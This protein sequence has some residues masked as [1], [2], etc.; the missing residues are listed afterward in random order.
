[1]KPPNWYKHTGG[2][3]TK[4][5]TN[6]MR[7]KSSWTNKKLAQHTMHLCTKRGLPTP[8]LSKNP[9]YHWKKVSVVGW[10]SWWNQMNMGDAN[11]DEDEANAD[12]DADDGADVATAPP[13]RRCGPSP[14]KS[15]T[16]M[17][18][19][20]KLL[21]KGYFSVRDWYSILTLWKEKH[22]RSSDNVEVLVNFKIHP[23]FFEY[24]FLDSF[25]SKPLHAISSKQY[26]AFAE[27]I[28]GF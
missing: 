24:W 14:K 5:D 27:P 15:G 4:E 21:Q 6:K 16:P 19:S 26:V 20:L 8:N 17:R 23:N 9:W 13:P 11:E 10:S 2:S 25:A 12:A 28:V 18:R 7:P 3:E 22:H 1:M